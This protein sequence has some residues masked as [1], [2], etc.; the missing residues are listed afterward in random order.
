MVI[1]VIAAQGGE[2]KTILTTSS[3]DNPDP[4]W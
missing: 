4:A 3:D 2:S 1:D